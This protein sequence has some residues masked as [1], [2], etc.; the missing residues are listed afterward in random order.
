[1]DV[2]GVTGESATN[3][4]TG[5]VRGSVARS[6]AGSV[7]GVVGGVAG[8]G[9]CPGVVGLTAGAGDENEDSKV[10]QT[11]S[12]RREV[13]GYET[14]DEDMFDAMVK[15]RDTLSDNND[16]QEK[17]EMDVIVE[18]SNKELTTISK[19]D[20]PLGSDIL[21]ISPPPTLFSDLGD[22]ST[23]ED[24]LAVGNS[25]HQLPIR[26][27]D[28]STNTATTVETST[29]VSDLPGAESAS[30]VH[31]T[32]PDQKPIQQQLPIY[33]V[34][35]KQRNE[36]SQ[37][38]MGRQDLADYCTVGDVFLPAAVAAAAALNQECS[39]PPLPLHTAEMS[40]FGC[41]EGGTERGDRE[42][43][44]TGDDELPDAP[45]TLLVAAYESET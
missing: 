13:G 30:S 34:I 8:V 41:E 32:S 12:R 28:F 45:P 1:M 15:V 37:G 9:G 2:I 5:G 35:N 27:A 7:G 14:I 11:V 25:E 3:D 18:I 31:S 38:A 33:S 29:S 44:G 16:L 19:P 36:T 10:N 22:Y 6:T 4:V 26:N 42:E 24:V 39:P 20:S 23:I 17:Q 21:P 40:V 43:V